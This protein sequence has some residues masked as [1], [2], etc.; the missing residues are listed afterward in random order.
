MS[1]TTGF[2]LD[3]WLWHARFFKSRTLATAVVRQG[4]VRVNGTPV[5][6]SSRLVVVGDVLTFPKEDDVRVI[7]IVAE[8]QRR[9]PAPEAQSLYEDLA[10]PAPKVRNSE[11][12][13]IPSGRPDKH[14][15]KAIQKFKENLL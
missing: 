12:D 11:P 8:G 6:K 3:K 5:S 4:K 9:G 10:P 7:K 15:R 13:R 1:Q 14:E 2:R